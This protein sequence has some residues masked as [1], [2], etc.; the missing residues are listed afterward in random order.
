MTMKNT[1]VSIL[2]VIKEKILV[3]DG[4]MGTMIQGYSLQEEDYRGER[5]KDYPSPLQG[6]NDLLSITQ[7]HIVREIHAKYL[8]AG[9][10]LIETNTFSSTSI[11]MA[12]YDLESIVYELNF[13]SAKIAKEIANEYTLKDPSKPR[14]VIGSIGPTNK[15]ASLSP[16]V[17]NPGYRAISYDEL[18]TSYKEQVKGLVDGGVDVLLV[19]TV[20]DTLNAKAGLYAISQY[21]EDTNTEP[22]P[23]MIS[24]TITD[25][26]GRTLS[27]QT[28]EAFLYS[29]S[30]FPL[31]SVGI[32]CAL[33][34]E[35]M[36]P[37]IE[38]LSNEA[39]FYISVYP[40]AGLPNE[41]GEYDQTP[42]TMADQVEDFL[43]SKFINIIGGCCGTNDEHIKA[44]SERV[45]NYSPREKPESKM[46]PQLSG[47]EPLSIFEGSNFINIGERTNIAGSAKFRKLIKDEQYEAALDVALKQVENGA[48]VIDINMDEGMIDSVE[49]MKVFLNLIGS[50]PDICKVPIM[51]DSSKWEVLEAGLKCI[52]GKGIVNSISLKGGEEE[53]KYQAN[54][55]KKYGA[56]VVVM[57]FDEVG[58]ADSFERRIEICQRSYDI[59]VNEVNFPAQDIIFDPNIL[60]VATGID[61]HNNYGVDFINATR[62]IKENLPYAKVSG[63]VSNISFSFRG[64][65]SVREAMH[66]V[67]LYHA[68]Q[69]GLD[70]GIVN[71]GMIE[72]YDQIPKD[73][74][75]ACEDVILNRNSEG[76]EV[77][78]DMAESF[79]GSKKERKVDLE[80]RK[81]PVEKRLQHSL[82]RGIVEFIEADT[83]EARQKFD[84]PIEVIEIPLMDGMNIVGDLF[85]EGKMFL[86]QVV[87]S[88]RVMKRAVAYLQPY[89]EDEKSGA[90]ISTAGKILMATVKGDVHDIGKNIVSV[91]LGCNN[92]EIIDIGVMVPADKIIKAALEHNVDIIGLSGLITPS[93]DEMVGVAKEMQ[94][95]GL[96]IP[97]MVGGAT[98][99][100]IHTAVKIDPHYEG[101]IV[102]VSDAS[103]SVPVAGKLA[104]YL[105]KIKAETK[106][107]YAEMR[108][109][110][111]NRKSTNQYIS[112]SDALKNRVKIDWESYKPVTPQFTGTKVFTDL[113][114]GL[115]LPFID[116]TPF[117]MAWRLKGSYPAILTDEKYGEEATKVFDDAQELLAKI[118]K[119]KLFSPRAVIGF[120][121]AKSI[122]D[123]IELDNGMNLNMLRSQRKMTKSTSPNPSLADYISPNEDFMG[124]FAVTTGSEAHF[125]ADEY[126]KDGD[127][128]NSIMVKVL[129]D[130]IAEATAEFMHEQVRKL[131]WGYDTNEALSNN[132]LIREKYVGIRPAPGYAACPD[133]TEKNELFKM[134][135]VSENIGVELTE[136]CA[137]YPAS[138]VSGWY[139]SH[140]ESK[141]FNVGSIGKDQIKSYAKRKNMSVAEIEKWMA[142]SLS[143]SV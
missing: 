7:P 110:H 143:Y 24:G 21:F 25:A 10:D 109:A 112:Y 20:F 83:E 36:R 23:V 15:T 122:D 42:E 129:A 93:L 90:A 81:L 4:G 33:G 17:N 137:M 108:E 67:F 99:S 2:D 94:R 62:W 106:A 14:F 41:F 40:N 121:G 3:L 32:N 13:E 125:L 70:M 54:E 66:S 71:A 45:Q 63:G 59:L 123:T 72:V 22:L 53:F 69:A 131:Y 1:Q 103:R 6:N 98:T 96:K 134:L 80:W 26:S 55:V 115:L 130:R 135:K 52:Q 100:R 95:Q 142:T 107:Q 50:E 49:V 60:T 46:Y 61:E 104:K 84:K 27:G 28:I 78:V 18:V 120:F 127:D 43:Q 114:L 141:Y 101:A 113:N 58:Q 37:Y 75:K 119:E 16:D 117:F 111:K 5:F 73:L 29:V 12:D 102:H 68:I 51:I 92:Y 31:L 85:G 9:S 65:N 35:L 34:A 139:I 47:L 76:T 82:V 132:D 79:K 97:L 116:W 38:R 77:L 56:A 48:Q 91:V 105:S 11:A 87:K 86:P 30:H 57:A 126:A 140:P 138:S 8:E 128:Y 136:S 39:P 64:N 118:V 44:I 124:A 88:A 74:L 19:E 89:I 133:H